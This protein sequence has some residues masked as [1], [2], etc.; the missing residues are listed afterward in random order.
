M[1]VLHQYGFGAKWRSWVSILLSTSS[2]AVL[3]NGTRGRWYKHFTG[4]RQ[5]DPLSPMLFILSME[6]L[7]RMF[8]VSTQSGDLSTLHT[9]A[10][11]RVSLFADDAAVF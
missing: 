6:P 3:L 5:G 4:L 8:E 2:S 1:E 7:Q 11:L 9:R 10:K